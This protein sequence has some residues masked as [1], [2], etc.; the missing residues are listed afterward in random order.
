MLPTISVVPA[1]TAIILPVT[2]I[3]LRG[4]SWRVTGRGCI[5]LNLFGLL[6]LL[7]LLGRLVIGHIIL[8][9]GLV[10]FKSILGAQV[11]ALLHYALHPGLLHLEEIYFT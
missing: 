7:N 11:G 2:V 1:M 9:P 5:L 4:L 8:H 10:D 6:V 3:V